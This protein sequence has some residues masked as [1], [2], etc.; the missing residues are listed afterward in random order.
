MLC[1]TDDVAAGELA[2]AAGLALL[3]KTTSGTII[4]TDGLARSRQRSGDELL[5]WGSKDGLKP[6][7]MSAHF[8]AQGVSWRAQRTAS[9]IFL[10]MTDWL[11]MEPGSSITH[12]SFCGLAT[13]SVDDQ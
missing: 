3:C 6:L 10:P 11:A 2:A 13:Y 8:P 12:A 4:A 9:D 7:N 5:R 1:S